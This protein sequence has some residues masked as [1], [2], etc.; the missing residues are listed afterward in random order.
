MAA[1]N[2]WSANGR[3]PAA[4]TQRAA[5][6]GRFARITGDGST[7]MTLRPGGSYEPVPAPTFSTVR[8]S[9]SAA[10][11][12]AAIRGS[13]RRVVAQVTPIPS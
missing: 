4:A 10:Q 8:A 11:I 1:S 2:D 12:R 7:A 13:V 9:P 6:A 3:L 5:P